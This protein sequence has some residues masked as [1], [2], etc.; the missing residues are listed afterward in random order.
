MSGITLTKNTTFTPV[1][2]AIFNTNISNL[3]KHDLQFQRVH[4]R[5]A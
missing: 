1:K 5:G 3:K 2:N 4:S